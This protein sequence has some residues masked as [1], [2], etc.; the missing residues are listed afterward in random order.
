[1]ELPRPD[2]GPWRPE[3]GPRVASRSILKE[4]FSTISGHDDEIVVLFTALSVISITMVI[5][6]LP[7]PPRHAGSRVPGWIIRI[8]CYEDTTDDIQSM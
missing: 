1:M 2:L 4:E 7:M 5:R 8:I 3:L 6:H